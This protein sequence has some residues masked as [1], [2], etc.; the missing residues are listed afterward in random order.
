[1]IFF[2][3]FIS[4]NIRVEKIVRERGACAHCLSDMWV[5][6][7]WNLHVGETMGACARLTRYRLMRNNH[8]GQLFSL[9]A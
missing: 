7:V 1:M 9:F 3:L 6:Y 4:I 8:N 2:Y 5:Q